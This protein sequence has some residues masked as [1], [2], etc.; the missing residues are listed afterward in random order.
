MSEAD[1]PVEEQ[2]Q[3]LIVLY[4]PRLWAP[5]RN[6]EAQVHRPFTRIFERKWFQGLSRDQTYY[7]TVESFKLRLFQELE[8]SKEPCPLPKALKA[9]YRRFIETAELC[10]CMPQWWQF[11]TAYMLSKRFKREEPG[12]WYSMTRFHAPEEL[13]AFYGDMLFVKQLEY[14]AALLETSYI[15]GS[16]TEEIARCGILVE[17]EIEGNHL[18]LPRSLG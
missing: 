18:C 5:A 13:E 6:L 4:Y 15:E 12:G 9:L 1:T 8:V 2:V 7:M 11:N 16:D 17:K 14:F 10:Q 3:A